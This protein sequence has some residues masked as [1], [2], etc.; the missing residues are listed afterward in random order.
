MARKKTGLIHIKNNEE[1]DVNQD[2][3]TLKYY[4]RNT[5][6]E[7]SSD[8]LTRKNNKLSKKSNYNFDKPYQAQELGDEWDHYCWGANDF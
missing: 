3:V 4:I 2:K 7:I 5:D 6:V 1:F 8:K